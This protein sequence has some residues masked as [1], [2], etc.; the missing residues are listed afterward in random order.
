MGITRTHCFSPP[1]VKGDQ[2][3]KPTCPGLEAR[4]TDAGKSNRWHPLLTSS[5]IQRAILPLG[6]GRR[7]TNTGNLKKVFIF[8][9]RSLAEPAR[10]DKHFHT[11]SQMM[12]RS[13]PASSADPCRMAAAPNTHAKRR[14]QQPCSTALDSDL[15]CR[16]T[17]CALSFQQA[18]T[19]FASHPP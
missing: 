15:L 10:S 16:Y 7:R 18:P 11:S 13:S 2:H 19:F 8:P 5:E 6:T 12:L 3:A 1:S 17:A 4:G 9:T 14:C